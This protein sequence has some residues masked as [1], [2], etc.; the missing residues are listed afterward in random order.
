VRHRPDEPVAAASPAAP[1]F[2]RRHVYR[3]S[4]RRY[5]PAI[6]EGRVLL[7]RAA[8][9]PAYRPDLGWSRL[10]PHLEVDVIPGEHLTCITRHVAA[11]AARLEQALR[12]GED[13]S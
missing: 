11:F 1:A 13:E 6:Y 10:I 8:D 12:E 4:F 9:D 2:G 5:A 3:G 7:L